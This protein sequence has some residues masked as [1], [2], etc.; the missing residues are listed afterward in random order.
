MEYVGNDLIIT[1]A[2]FECIENEFALEND[3]EFDWQYKLLTGEREDSHNVMFLFRHDNK[4]WR[5]QFWYDEADGMLDVKTIICKEVE[6]YEVT[7]VRYRNVK[8]T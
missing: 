2:D 8:H 1:H 7:V 5:G 6:P 3:E 4:L